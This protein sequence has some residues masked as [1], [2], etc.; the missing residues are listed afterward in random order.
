MC[1]PQNDMFDT[2]ANC[3]DCHEDLLRSA[4]TFNS[5]GVP[6]GLSSGHPTSS[7]RSSGKL[8]PCTAHRAGARSWGSGMAGLSASPRDGFNLD[9]RSEGSPVER[10][11][12]RGLGSSRKE[13]FKA[14]ERARKQKLQELKKEEKR[15]DGNASKCCTVQ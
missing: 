11:S 10:H 7:L 15:R 14:A 9:V 6:V 4:H 12:R 13:V 5:E 1:S 2:Q 8:K 3:P